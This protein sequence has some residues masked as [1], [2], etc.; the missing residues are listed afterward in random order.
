[1]QRSI[2]AP[3]FSPPYKVI[4]SLEALL[5]TTAWQQDKIKIFGQE[6]LFPRLTAWYGDSGKAYQDFNF[7]NDL[8]LG[9]LSCKISKKY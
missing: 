5:T 3:G 1:M 4:I 2:I 8:Y 7:I 9:N 6:E